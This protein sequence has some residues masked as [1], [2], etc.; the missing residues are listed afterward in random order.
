MNRNSQQYL[1]LRGDVLIP[2]AHELLDL[3]GTSYRFKSTWKFNEEA[4]ADG[5]DLTT[6]VSR[7]DRTQNLPVFFKKG[8]CKGFIFFRHCCVVNNVSKH[9]CGEFALPL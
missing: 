4:V 6:S 5:L 9:D 8:Q 2:V 1:S 7:K 3:L